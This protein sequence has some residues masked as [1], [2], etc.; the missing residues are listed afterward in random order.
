MTADVAQLRERREISALDDH[1]ARRLGALAG[2]ERPDVLLAV[3]LASRSVG[4]GH[5][6]L[7]LRRWGDGASLLAGA[8]EEA[9]AWP[10]AD[11]WIEQL[12]TS[13]IIEPLPVASAGIPQ[14]PRTITVR[15]LP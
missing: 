9:W 1:F 14:L 15:G 7:D 12:E 8:D 4:E 2:E 10:K 5:V 11:A 6:C 13:A 3:A